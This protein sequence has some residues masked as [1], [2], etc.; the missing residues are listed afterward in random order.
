V[1][2]PPC[3]QARPRRPKWCSESPPEDLP[4]KKW[5]R[6][7]PCVGHELATEGPSVGLILRVPTRS[8]DSGRRCSSSSRRRLLLALHAPAA[9]VLCGALGKKGAGSMRCDSRD[10]Q[11]P[12]GQSMRVG[13][14]WQFCCNFRQRQGQI[15]SRTG[16]AGGEPRFLAPWSPKGSSHRHIRVILT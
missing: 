7:I 1:W 11:W 6:A 13:P 9:A 15:G 10:G 14:R 5:R 8:T 12:V 2:P 16:G 4:A 3:R